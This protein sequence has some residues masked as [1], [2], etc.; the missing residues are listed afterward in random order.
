M[1]PYRRAPLAR[2]SVAGSVL[3]LPRRS[4]PAQ[5]GVTRHEVPGAIGVGA[6]ST[7]RAIATGSV[8]HRLARPLTLKNPGGC[9]GRKATSGRTWQS[10]RPRIPRIEMFGW[11][12]VVLVETSTC[13]SR[14][15]A[16]GRESSC[17]SSA[18]SGLAGVSH[19]GENARQLCRPAS[20]DSAPRRAL[21]RAPGPVPYDGRHLDRGKPRALTCSAADR[22]QAAGNGSARRDQDRALAKGCQRRSIDRG[23]VSRKSAGALARGTRKRPGARF[24]ERDKRRRSDRSRRACRQA[25]CCWRPDD[26]EVVRRRGTDGDGGNASPVPCSI[27]LANVR[28]EVAERCLLPGSELDA[29]GVTHGARVAVS[30]GGVDSECS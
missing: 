30:R 22:G 21:E 13:R 12:V 27:C 20:R 24:D 14:R 25:R 17:E 5:E 19:S 16:R 7:A 1:P 28:A 29:G 2:A 4:R 3:F 6:K 8:G 15:G 18:M 9:L 11:S 10:S 23:P 26:R